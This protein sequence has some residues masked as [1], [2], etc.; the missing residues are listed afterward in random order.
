MIKSGLVSAVLVLVLTG[1]CARADTTPSVTPVPAGCEPIGDLL[2]WLP[3][4]TTAI[5]TEASLYGARELTAGATGT[6]L[7]SQPFTPSITGVAA[8]ASWLTEL[9]GSLTRQTGIPVHLTAPSAEGQS[10]GVPSSG[11]E[12]PFV[13]YTG[14]DRVSADFEVRCDP[15]VRGTFHAWSRTISGGVSCEHSADVRLDAFGHLALQLCPDLP[16]PPPSAPVDA[17]EFHPEDQPAR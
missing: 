16:K 1:A 17:E 5:L 15:T 12:V 4:R 8:P 3:A 6:S 13:L 10:F 2:T 11:E 9:G 14:V 7:M